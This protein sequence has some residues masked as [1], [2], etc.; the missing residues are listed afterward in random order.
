MIEV[1]LLVDCRNHLGESPIWD[2]E[3]QW[4]YWVD[5][6][7]CEIWR[8][9]F[10]GS[11]LETLYVPDFIGTIA[12]RARGGA[13][14]ALANGFHF[15]DLRKQKVE[16]IKN[17]LEDI[18]DY[19]FNDGKVDRAGRLFV[20]CMGYDF[21]RPDVNKVISPAQNG[22]VFRLDPDLSVHQIDQGM[23]CFNAPCWSPDNRTFYYG[24]TEQGV[25]WA[26][27]YD[28]SNGTSSNR[29]VFARD[30]GFAGLVDGATVDAEG[31]VWNAKVLG[32]RLVRYAPDGSVDR[33][34]QMPV[35]NVTSVAFGGP[36]LDILFVTSMAKPVRGVVNTQHGAGGVFA[37]SGLGVR[38]IPE[39]RFAG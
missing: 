21:E 29:R 24:D 18:P 3:E 5:S 11:E 34:I 14:L 7:G 35:R 25:L 32:G 33:V 17:P 1:T 4:L 37:V 30:A 9:R 27:D 20:G 10:D 28:L 22:P 26:S 8:C 13:I 6:T 19:R 39:T 36:D 16:L 23:S 2:A 38:G 12:L 31:Y 15:Y